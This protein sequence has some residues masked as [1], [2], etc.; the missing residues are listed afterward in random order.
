MA[1]AAAS[2]I[3]PYGTHLHRAAAPWPAFLQ[4][5][6][7][8]SILLLRDLSSSRQIGAWARSSRSGRNLA[9]MATMLAL[10]LTRVRWLSPVVRVVPRGRGMRNLQNRVLPLIGGLHRDTPSCPTPAA[11]CSNN[12]PLRTTFNTTSRPTIRLFPAGP[13]RKRGREKR[14]E[15]WPPGCRALPG[16]P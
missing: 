4:F 12:R 13:S 8:T 5:F 6:C 11:P 1:R 7:T 9:T 16:R 15:S 2:R 3:C 10:I 14:F